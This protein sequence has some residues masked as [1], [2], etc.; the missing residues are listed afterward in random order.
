M[1]VFHIMQKCIKREKT[2]TNI[3]ISYFS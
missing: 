2:D 3:I 1:K